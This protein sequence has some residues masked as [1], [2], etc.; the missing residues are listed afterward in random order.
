M[1]ES[2]TPPEQQSGHSRAGAHAARAQVIHAQL[3]ASG[4]RPLSV[5][6]A[7]LVLHV[8]V[9]ASGL[10]LLGPWPGLWLI[11][12][13]GAL[14]VWASC[15]DVQR[16][17]IPDWATVGLTGAALYWIATDPGILWLEHAIG[18]I[19]WAGSFEIIRRVF[20]WRS[21][22]DGLGFG[23]VKL[24]APLALLCG[25]VGSAQMVF[26]AATAAVAVMLSVAV[27]RRQAVANIALP[28]GPFLCFA[29]WIV[30]ISGL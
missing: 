28:F 21:G 12:G 18:A 13:I 14:L 10:A 29:T 16:F 1:P 27:L 17:E 4:H 25:P 23:D 8:L 15:V 9:Y 2:S 19:F 30:W 22:F 3:V 20:I 24:M 26:L 11:W 7:S 5:A 6:C